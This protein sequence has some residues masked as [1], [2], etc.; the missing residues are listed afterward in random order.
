MEMTGFHIGQAFILCL[1]TI[2]ALGDSVTIRRYV[3][4]KKGIPKG[5]TLELLVVA[6]LN[7]RPLRLFAATSPTA[8]CPP[9]D[10]RGMEKSRLTRNSWGKN[11]PSSAFRFLETSGCPRRADSFTPSLSAFREA[12]PP[13]SPPP[14]SPEDVIHP[15]FRGS[16][17]S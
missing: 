10:R 3:Q 16:G 17:K 6:A 4:S 15:V 14:A 13:V 8:P 7:G 5:I 1:G 2:V 9:R 12:G 11:A